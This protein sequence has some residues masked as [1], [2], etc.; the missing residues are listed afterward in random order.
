MLG[1]LNDKNHTRIS[2]IQNRILVKELGNEAMFVEKV[3]SKK[4]EKLFYKTLR[5]V[6][7][8][9]TPAKK[10]LPRA[11]SPKSNDNV[12][13]KKIKIKTDLSKT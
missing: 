12:K 7:Q 1:L 5:A 2:A 3:G 8:L 10:R 9:V 11:L 4:F 6:N 13:A